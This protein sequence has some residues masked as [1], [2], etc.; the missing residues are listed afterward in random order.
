[1]EILITVCIIHA[2]ENES[3]APNYRGYHGQSSR[4]LFEKPSAGG[5]SV[6]VTQI[7][8]CCKYEGA[9]NA[10]EEAVGYE[11]RF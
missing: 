2:E 4:N 7:T 8:S 5:N 6:L 10:G 9:K 11:E 1:M 3:H